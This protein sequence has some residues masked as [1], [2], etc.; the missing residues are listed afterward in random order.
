MAKSKSGGTRSLI[1]GRVA[2]DVYSIGR[3][4]MG[5]RQQVV[6]SLAEVVSNPR[7]L[8][9]MRSRM[10]MSTVMQAQSALKVIV[11]HSFDNVSGVQPNLSEFIRRNYALIKADVAAHPAAGNNF[12]LVAYQEQGAKQGAYIVS[13]GKA[14]FPA[15]ITFVQG[16]AVMTITLAGESATFG[17]LK[18][19]WEVG[20]EGYLTIVG[21]N[22]S[23]SADYARLHLASGIADSTVI[24]ADNLA[25]CF[26]IEG[27]ANPVLAIAGQNIT[28][29]MASIAG[30]SSVIVTRKAASGFIHSKAVLG[31]AHDLPFNANTA[32]PSYPVG[33]Q[34]FLNGGDSQGASAPVAPTP[35]PSQ[36]PDTP[37]VVE[38]HLSTFSV[39]GANLLTGTSS[40][41]Q[42][43]EKS[44][45]AVLADKDASKSY[46]LVHKT[47]GAFTVGENA[48]DNAVAFEGDTLNATATLEQDGT[49]YFAL[50]EDGKV[51]QVLGTLRY[52]VNSGGGMD[53]N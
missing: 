25:S 42:T 22:A 35:T 19:A 28:V 44:I 17:A 24:T 18:E 45:Y 27:D 9:Q 15:A 49:L 34:K 33:E 29:T 1:R 5:K 20:N 4:A 31:A 12:G 52:Y 53:Q 11:D 26:N 38:P 46:A 43:G 2:S 41:S 14:A 50:T 37:A 3:D 10:I 23:G 6:R 30:C 48:S 8:A 16:T 32:L 13:D 21:I 7:T 51:K 36:D 40:T 39:A 47:S